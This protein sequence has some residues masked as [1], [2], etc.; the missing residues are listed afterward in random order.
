MK[1]KVIL[2]FDVDG[3]LLSTGGA[4]RRAMA[5]AFAEICGVGDAL[6][7]IRLG[8]MTDRLILRTGLERVG[9]PFEEPIFARI[10]G[11]YLDLLRV[12][13]ER[14]EGYRVLP[15]VRELLQRLTGVNGLA[16][17]LGTGNVRSGARIKLARAEL[18]RVF[19]FGG[20][21]CD[22]ED[23]AELLGLGAARGA[24]QLGISADEARIVVIGDTPKD[25]LAARAIGAECVAVATGSHSVD[26]LREAGAERVLE[27]LEAPE[28]FA[29][30]AHG[31]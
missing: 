6:D 21:G 28:A 27:S 26:E 22:A 16:L 15:G 5:R 3:T 10:V 12:E 4:G 19:D 7:G 1:R 17:G 8:G 25:I 11:V 23:R 9:R 30:I 20:F 24:A 14:S 2:L 29:R 31:E 13:V 18:H